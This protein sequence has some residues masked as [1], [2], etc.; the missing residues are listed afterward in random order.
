[1]AQ[2]LRRAL[3]VDIPATSARI[4]VRTRRPAHQAYLLLYAA[5][6]AAPLM[7]GID[8]FFDVLAPWHNYLAP[9]VAGMLPVAPHTFMMA[10]GVVE[11]IAAI[12][13]AAK[14][15]IGGYVVALWLWGIIVNLLL[16]RG[17][18]DIALRDFG[19]SLAALALAR[20]AIQFE[21]R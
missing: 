6:I 9:M 19:L 17:F 4:D 11:I 20:L 16:A 8:K 15:S 7:A 14:P 12:L 3:E 1:M 18:Y 5:F 21:R 13:V 2:P 10:V